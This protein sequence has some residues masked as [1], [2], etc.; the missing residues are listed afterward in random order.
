VW[1]PV[2]AEENGCLDLRALYPTAPTGTAL[3]HTFFEVPAE[4]DYVLRIGS[5]D[6]VRVDLDGRTVHTNRVRRSWAADQDLVRLRLAKGWHRLLV[7]VVDYGGAWAASV[8][9]ADA[10]DQPIAEIRHQATVP[11]SLYRACGMDE[12]LPVG[13]SA[14]ASLYLTAQIEALETE[15]AAARHRLAETPEGYVTFAEYEGARALG[16]RFI[17]AVAALWE[18]TG[19]ST[20]DADAVREAHRSA[21][22]AAR[23]FSEILAEETEKLAM[24]MTRGHRVWEV[25]SGNPPRRRDAAAAVLQVAE[26]LAQTRR[27]AARVEN[28]RV[29]AARF[30]ND[31]R[32]FRQRE[33]TIRVVN[34]EGG[35]V[36]DAEVEIVQAGHDFLFGCNL[37]AF[38]RFG[39]EKKNALYERRFRDLFNLAVVP[40]YWSVLEKNRGRPEFEAT[41][42]AVRWCR[43]HH[44]QVRLHPLLWSDTLP[45]WFEDL[46]AEDALEAARLHVR[47]V[48]ERYREPVD[49]WDVLQRPA[50]PLPLGPATIDPAEALRWSA[51]AKPRG[52]LL[53]GGG[54]AEALADAARNVRA[55]GAR[56]DGVCA[57]AQQHE[58]AWT[59]D[60]LR[61]TLDTAAR[62][63]VPVYV[64]EVAI[65][66]GPEDE[67]GQ[68]EAVRNFY[69][70]AFAHPRVAG[71]TWW[72]LSDRFALKNA[73]AGLLRPDLA[74]KPAYRAL[75]RLINRAWQTDAAG[76]TDRDGRVMVRAFLGPYRVTV[77]DG[78]RKT[79]A[80]VHLS[81]DG[82]GEFE[83]VLPPPV[84]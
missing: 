17:D 9:V 40:V 20:W 8:R 52:R 75:D 47:Q 15:L 66:G 24:A 4:G 77:R 42:V 43:D 2:K 49:F 22:E 11:D 65:L 41:D 3:L 53:I 56:L 48:I 69:T 6:A 35:P 60:Q 63:D 58:G 59:L 73:P 54:P 71:I 46:G 1:L 26:L 34:V 55:A 27:L 79:T 33:M 83:V 74:P 12:P 80:E 31:I 14:A 25:L 84:K 62:A 29:Q 32:N 19:R 5:D 72:D 76:R 81:R 51:E 28:V 38:R 30:E 57:A 82:P 16:L 23:G 67:A 18:E 45:R 50:A 37:F 36:A 61:K 39:D 70:A 13:E 68:A 7:R 10:K 64:S 44:I 21:A 78:K